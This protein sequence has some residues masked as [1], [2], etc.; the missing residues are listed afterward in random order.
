MMDPRDVFDDVVYLEPDTD[1][2]AV[3]VYIHPAWKRRLSGLVGA[4]KAAGITSASMRK[5][6]ERALVNEYGQIPE[7]AKE[8]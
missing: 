3:Q 6:V 8:G 2:T 1:Q 4:Q 5:L 7:L